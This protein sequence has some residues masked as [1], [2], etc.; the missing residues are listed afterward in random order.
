MDPIIGNTTL[1]QR[2][3]GAHMHNA[4][5]LRRLTPERSPWFTWGRAIA[6]GAAL[7]IAYQFVRL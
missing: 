2:V 1:H 5:Y 4:S 6:V 7:Y 3:L